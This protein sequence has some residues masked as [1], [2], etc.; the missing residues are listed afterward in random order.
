MNRGA[1]LILVVALGALCLSSEALPMSAGDGKLGESASP[2]QLAPAAT[3]KKAAQAQEKMAAATMAVKKEAAKVAAKAA[4]EEKKL[5]KVVEKDTAQKMKAIKEDAEAVE[6][7]YVAKADGKG[8]QDM[9]DKLNWEVQNYA[10]LLLLFF[11][12]Q[13]SDAHTFLGRSW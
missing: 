6:K 11:L 4:M 8:K 13:D 12:P 7:E 1:M 2:V 3:L 9:K 5:A 10:V